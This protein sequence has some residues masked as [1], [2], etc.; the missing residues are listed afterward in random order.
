MAA[1]VP[2]PGMAAYATAKT[3]V[4]A[5]G[6]ALRVEVQSYGVRVGVGYFSWIDTEMV[7]GTDRTEVGA[8]MRAMLKGPLAKSYPVSAPPRPSRGNR[9]A[10]PHR[11]LPALA[12][13][14]MAIRPLLPG[15]PS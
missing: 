9:A 15:C 2:G 12:A 1:I 14:L 3:G 4:E 10:P 11:R 5:F 13:V 8:G 6:N 7:R